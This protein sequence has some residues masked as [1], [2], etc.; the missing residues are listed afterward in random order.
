MKRERFN[1]NINLREAIQYIRARQETIALAKRSGDTEKAIQLAKELSFSK[2]ARVIAVHKVVTNKGQ[3]SKGLSQNNLNTN[4]EYGKMVDKLLTVIKNPKEYKATPLDRI[5]IPKKNRKLRPVS[6][7]SYID[8]CLQVL[9][10]I[11]IEPIVEE[12][13]DKSSYDF[14]PIRNTQ[15]AAGRCLNLLAN[16]LAK[17]NF[18]LEINI[19]GCYDNI[20]HDFLKGIIPVIPSTIIWEWL[21][22]GY[23]ERS[24]N[25]LQE[26]E[27]GVPQGGIISPLL[28]NIT[29]DG[30][31][32]TLAIKTQKKYQPLSS[33]L[34]RYADDIIYFTNT[35]DQA[36]EVKEYI[37]EFLKKRGLNINEAKSSITNI[38]NDSFEFVGYKFRKVFRRNKKLKVARIC[39]PLSSRR[40]F[41][42]KIR[43]L[44]RKRIKLHT[45]IDKVNEITRGW[46]GYYK[47]AHDS[48]YIFRSL[49]YWIWKQYYSKCYRIISEQYDK[50]NHTEIHEKVIENYFKPFEN[51]SEWPTI[52]DHT[53]KIHTLVDITK[54]HLINP[55]YTNQA[56][57]PYITEDLIKLERTQLKNRDKNVKEKVMENYDG[58]CGLCKRKFSLL[59]KPFEIHHIKPRKFGGSNSPKNLMPLCR[60]PCHNLVTS[61][62]KK[63]DNYEI[64]RLVE[65]NILDL[66]EEFFNSVTDDL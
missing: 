23:I 6:I 54:Y 47:F 40:K 37:N 31:E 4:E 57:N 52:V 26:T 13:M 24:N 27:K 1:L 21:K 16:P 34:V 49:R 41:Q 43:E 63:K 33:S 56:Q 55:V 12:E 51:Y 15:W 44:K 35:Y 7:P 50:A 14:R 28:A 8:R 20:N 3:R 48:I 22:S 42:T 25:I 64:K 45:Y 19:E 5:Y 61:S 60:E 46:A 38:N 30:L 36:L 39:I 53:G 18:V 32:L 9:Y 62:M 65:L 2:E 29:L 59:E 10:L 11:A 58:C 17:Y 66:P